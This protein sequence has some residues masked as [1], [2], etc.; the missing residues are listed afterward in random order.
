MRTWQASSPKVTSR[1]QCSRFSTR[2]SGLLEG[3]QPR[4]IRLLSGQIGQAIDQL[5]P[6][7]LSIF[8]RAPQAKDLCDPGPLGLKPVIHLGTRP[9]FADF[10]SPMPFLD[11]FGRLPLL[12]LSLGV[13]KE[14]DQVLVQLRLIQFDDGKTNTPHK[15]A[16]RHTTSFAYASHRY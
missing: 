10:Q 7:L 16:H 5:L 8:H 2:K 12:G 3:Q 11:A 1:L 13:V 15:H 6:L 4:S 9:D 14:I